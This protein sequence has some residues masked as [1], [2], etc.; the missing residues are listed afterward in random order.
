MEP[1]AILTGIVGIF[2][3]SAGTYAVLRKDKREAKELVLNERSQAQAE[4]AETIRLLEKQN[5]LLRNQNDLLTAQLATAEKREA[6]AR[7]RERKLE[8]RVDRLD[9]DYRKLVQT[10][11]DSSICAEANECEKFNPGDRRKKSGGTNA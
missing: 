8:A 1:M 11:T 2:G 9:Q 3:G 6:E 10:V 7:E 4:A 5:E